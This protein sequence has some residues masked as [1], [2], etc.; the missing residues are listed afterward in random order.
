M[1]LK[2]YQSINENNILSYSS[3]IAPSIL[4]IR[5]KTIFSHLNDP[6]TSF[7]S[8]RFL[9]PWSELE[10]QLQNTYE[11]YVTNMFASLTVRTPFLSVSTEWIVIFLYIRDTNF[12]PWQKFHL[13]VVSNNVCPSTDTDERS[14]Y[15]I[16]SNINSMHELEKREIA[17]RGSGCFPS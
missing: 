15:D 7:R 1:N 10:I 13:P 6:E 4:D 16:M 11:N 8:H 2:I 5:F 12:L 9:Y 14:K 3:V 17:R